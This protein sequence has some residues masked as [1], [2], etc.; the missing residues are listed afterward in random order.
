MAEGDHLPQ[1]VS[2][3]KF[4]RHLLNFWRS[5]ERLLRGQK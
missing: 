4:N 2:P 3:A 5:R 1:M